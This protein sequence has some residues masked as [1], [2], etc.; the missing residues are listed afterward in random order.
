MK[1]VSLKDIARMTGASP[2]TVSFVLNGKAR[3]MRISDDLAKKI[4]TIARRE[5]Y[6]PNQVAVRL[7]TGKSQMLGL[8]VESIS[9]NFFASLAKVI[10]EAA[11][12]YGYKVVYCATENDGKKGQE[13]IR[14]L[15][16]QQVDGYIITPAVGMEHDVEELIDHKKPVVLLDSYFPDMDVPHV[17]V[18]NYGG[19]AKGM[20]HLIGRGYRKIGF[21]TVDLQLIQMKDRL[22]AYSDSL[23]TAGIP[24]NKKNIL[25]LGYKISR[26]DAI[27]QISAF[28]VNNPQLEALFFATNYL[29]LLGI[30][31]LQ[32]L[33]KTIP[34][35]VAMMSFDDH[36]VFRLFP[37]GITI[38]EQ[39]VEEIAK[40]AINLLMSQLGKNKPSKKNKV[41]LP[42]RLVVR[43]TT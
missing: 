35:D 42:A 26:A 43:G 40:T 19:V 7:R 8:V 22:Q 25:S 37:P 38:I 17:L 15:S 39:P 18:D 9:G 12:Q 2:S 13:L 14:M 20:K 36:D 10:E 3:E 6:Q 1:R 32:Q 33:G 41:Q 27:K 31:S 34:G 29:G 23:K 21:I 30:E 16:Q 4:T 24:V 11:D 5:G 28:I